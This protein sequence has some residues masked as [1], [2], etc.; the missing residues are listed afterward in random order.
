MEVSREFSK[1][2]TQMPKNHLKKYLTFLDIKKVQ[3]E[4][5]LKI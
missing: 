3:I 5:Y 2:E 4:N 1:N